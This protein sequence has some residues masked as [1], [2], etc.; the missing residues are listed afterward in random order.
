[1]REIDLIKEFIADDWSMRQHFSLEEDDDVF[2]QL[3]NQ[4]YKR[5]IRDFR[6][7][8]DHA[9]GRHSPNAAL[10]VAK[11]RERQL[12]QIK[13]YEPP[14]GF[15]GSP[16]HETIYRAYVGPYRPGRR[17]SYASNFYFS[18]HEGRFVLIG[19]SGM[20]P[21]CTSLGMVD[22]ATCRACGGEG[23]YWLGS[24]K[25]ELGDLVRVH[26]IEAPTR[27]KCL[28]EYEAE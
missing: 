13:E 8:L 19:K 9:R 22:G 17:T 21:D 23:W 16:E 5:H 26:K 15:A 14:G 27:A 7:G 20:C 12:F 2:N 28:Q 6:V 24:K 11:E 18:W 3:R 25:V 4:F 10:Q 1:M